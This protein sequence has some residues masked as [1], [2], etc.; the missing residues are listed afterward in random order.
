M[1]LFRDELTVAL[2]S[3][4]V[5]CREAVD[6]HRAAAKAVDE[7]G[8]ADALAR[9]AQ[10]RERAA[11]YFADVLCRLSDGPNRPPEELEILKQAVVWG[12]AL[13]GGDSAAVLKSCRAQ[14]EKLV[15]TTADALKQS[16]DAATAR[17][18]KELREDAESCVREFSAFRPG[19]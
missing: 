2:D 8:L 14:E 12:R 18:L 13:I 15:R 7:P 5:A 4:A 3:V 10:A 1:E 19:A 9:L 16:M 17:Q 11:G 6:V